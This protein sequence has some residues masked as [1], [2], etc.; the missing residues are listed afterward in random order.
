MVLSIL[1]LTTLPV[2]AFTQISFHEYVPPFY[3]TRL[4]QPVSCDD[5]LNSCDILANLFDSCLCYPSWLVAFWNLRLKSSFFAATKFIRLILQLILLFKS[6]TY[7]LIFT[8]ITAFLSLHEKRFY[9]CTGNLCI[10]RRRASLATS[11]GT[12]AKLE[13]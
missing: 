12:P 9:I 3:S 6:S 1:S 2:R 7:L 10:A 13:Q 11:S 5:S 4:L 8:V